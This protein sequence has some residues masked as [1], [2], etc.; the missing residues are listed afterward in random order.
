MVLVPARDPNMIANDP[1]VVLHYRGKRPLGS[2]FDPLDDVDAVGIFRRVR[3][4]LPFRWSGPVFASSLD[5]MQNFK[6][7]GPTTKSSL[8]DESLLRNQLVELPKLLTL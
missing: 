4:I 8:A 1:A 5:T 7:A 2:Q 3:P 6:F